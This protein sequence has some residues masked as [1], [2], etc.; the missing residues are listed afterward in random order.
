[1]TSETTTPEDP[2]IKQ[3]KALIFLSIPMSLAIGAGLFWGVT[4]YLPQTGESHATDQ[5][6]TSSYAIDDLEFVAMDPI[7]VSM[8]RGKTKHHLRFK[9]ELEVPAAHQRDV[10][11]LIPRVVDVFNAFLRALDLD[12]IEHP[13][14]LHN[15]RAQ[16][17]RRAKIVLGDSKVNDLL[18]TEFVLN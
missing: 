16:M 6:I 15:I 17:L 11:K 14:A 5:Q 10:E 8:N 12:D 4:Q 18:V 13:T 3:G 2:P 1:M 7:V 9:A